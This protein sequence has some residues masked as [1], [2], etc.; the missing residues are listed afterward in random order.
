MN[1]KQHTF[2]FREG[3]SDEKGGC[4][5]IGGTWKDVTT[6][7][8]FKG[9]RVVMFSLPGAFT[10][11]CSS[12]ELP[13]YDR[14]YNEF[15]DMGID[16]VYCVSVNDA[17]VMN[18]WARDLEIQNVKMIPDGCGTFTSNMGMLVAKPAQGFGMRSWRYAAVVND[19]VVE[20]MFEEPGFNN[21]SDDDD[22][23][24]VSKPE[25]I[26]NYLNG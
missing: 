19:G 4:T 18:A 13:S 1:I 15:K 25:I 11:T 22:P 23:Y 8:L 10:P 26:K 20:K 7:D 24:V 6:D 9:K 21:F 12:E 14:M 16:D 3:D 5:F 2:K 17:F